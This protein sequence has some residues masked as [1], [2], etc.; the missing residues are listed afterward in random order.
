MLCGN[1]SYELIRTRYE[2]RKMEFENSVGLC[3]GTII[4]CGT[5]NSWSQTAISSIYNVPM[6][7]YPKVDEQRRHSFVCMLLRLMT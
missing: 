4:V 1:Q 7:E 3:L 6:A 5:Q 2:K